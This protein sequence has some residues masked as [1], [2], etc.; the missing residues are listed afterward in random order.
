MVLVI[1]DSLEV[2]NLLQEYLHVFFPV[3]LRIRR[4]VGTEEAITAIYEEKPEHVFIDHD[5]GTGTGL[6][7][8]EYFRGSAITFYSISGGMDADAMERYLAMGVELIGK[9]DPRLV[10]EKISSL[11]DASHTL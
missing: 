9:N 3:D 4:C 10:R 11:F 5:L 7:V 6:A 8:I 1:D 2:I